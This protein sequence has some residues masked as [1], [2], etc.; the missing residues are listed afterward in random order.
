[1]GKDAHVP[2]RLLEAALLTGSVVELAGGDPYNYIVNF[3]KSQS[4]NISE[5][6]ES[7]A[8]QELV[9]DILS[10]KVTISLPGIDTRITTIRSLLSDASDRSLLNDADCGIRYVEVEDKKKKKINYWLI[11]MW[12][13]LLNI[14]RENKSQLYKKDTPSRLKN[15]LAP[16]SNNVKIATA[17]K[18]LGKLKPYL[19][20]G[21]RR[22]D[23][24]IYD[25]TSIIEEWETNV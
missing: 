8:S 9:S 10:S 17:S 12:P 22:S 4:D 2:S 20:V 25:I 6:S 23:I 19:K 24:S 13:E 3:C 18:R 14:L 1:M 16:D 5:I 7:S 15:R 11:F 21:I